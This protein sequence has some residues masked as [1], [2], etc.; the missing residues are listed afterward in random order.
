MYCS[1]LGLD[2]LRS[3][4]ETD[5][6]DNPKKQVPK[7]AEGTQLRTALLKQCYMGPDV[8]NIFYSIEDPDL[9][10][11]FNQ[12]KKRL[13]FYKVFVIHISFINILDILREPALPAGT[14]L[15]SRSMSRDRVVPFK[16]RMIILIYEKV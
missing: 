5:D 1:I 3:D 2:D 6:E 10:V 11:M 15:L 8:D 16:L 7:W 4:S 12:Q 14:R 13:V 9:S